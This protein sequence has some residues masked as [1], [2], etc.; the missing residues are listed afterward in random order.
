MNTCQ[1]WLEHKGRYCKHKSTEV[2]CFQHTPQKSRNRKSRNRHSPKS[3]IITYHS[4]ENITANL[5]R[6]VQ[7]HSKRLCQNIFQNEDGF[8][9]H[10]I[11]PYISG[12]YMAHGPHQD[13]KG[14]AFIEQ[15]KDNHWYIELICAA[16]AGTLLMQRI[17]QDARAQDISSVYLYALYDR[18]TFYRKL[19][20]QFGGSRDEDPEITEIWERLPVDQWRH[21]EFYLSEEFKELMDCAAEHRLQHNPKASKCYGLLIKELVRNGIL[22]TWWT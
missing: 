17:Q 16:G 6:Q 11:W 15:V 4:K 5:K 12:V 13:L 1:Q 2:Y 8:F 10:R 3:V 20:F 9:T 21:P 19:G 22:M 18:L 14:F 7:R